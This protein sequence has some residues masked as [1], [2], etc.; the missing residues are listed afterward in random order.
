MEFG[1]L[2]RI[3]VPLSFVHGFALS[4]LRSTT[5]ELIEP[6]MCIVEH[7]MNRFSGAN[8]HQSCQLDDSFKLLVRDHLLIVSTMMTVT[9]SYL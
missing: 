6:A 8:R 5:E 9:L 1:I 7:K 4:A 2:L 3:Y